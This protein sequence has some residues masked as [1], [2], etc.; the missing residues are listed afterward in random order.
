MTDVYL[1]TNTP[2]RTRRTYPVTCWTCQRPF[3]VK[4]VPQPGMRHTCSPSCRHQKFVLLA[5]WN[6][7]TQVTQEGECWIW[8]GRLTKAGYGHASLAG[9]D[10]LAHHVP[11]AFARGP[12]APGV[13]RDHLCRHRACVHPGHLDPVPTRINILRGLSPVALNAQKT[14]CPAGHP[15]TADNILRTRHGRRCRTCKRQH[16][17]AR[18]QTWRA[19]NLLSPQAPVTHCYRGHPYDE[20]NTYWDTKGKRRCRACKRLLDRT[21]SAARQRRNAH[22]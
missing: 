10:V 20:E 12:L 15:Y 9:K 3:V 2:R 7:W 14:H 1:T 18:Y 4:K 21:S 22:A 8:H 13:H 5:R 16:D 11:W 17:H 6:F 19:A